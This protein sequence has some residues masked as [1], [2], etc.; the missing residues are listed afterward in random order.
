MKKTRGHQR[1]FTL[2]ELLVV[3]AII[4]VLIALLLPAVQQAREAARR[5]QCKNNMKQIGLAIHNYESSF[6]TFPSAAEGT[7]SSALYRQFFPV[8][9]FVQLLPYVDQAPLYGKWNFG[10]H[11]TNA[12]NAVLAKTP[13]PVYLCPSNGFSQPD[14]LGYGR[15][16]Y[17]PI[18][19]TDIDPVTGLRNGLVTG[20]SMGATRDG[21][22][23]L[24]GNRMAAVTDGLS[25]TIMVVEDNRI[26]T[27]PGAGSPTATGGIGSLPKTIG[28]APGIDVSQLCTGGVT[29]PDRWADPD[30]GS[31]ISGDPLGTLKVINNNSNPR[32]G[33]AGCPWTT[34]N[35][36]PNDEPFS[37]H[38]GGCHALLGDGSVRFLSE[39]MNTQ[40]VRRLSDKSDG[41]VIGEF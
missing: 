10:V 21:A 11:Y 35:C 27:T 30:I 2:I 7:N 31:G 32:G 24:Y 33:P 38:V 3:I 23:G 26:G 22:L 29:C 9:T 12:N 34:N 6:S 1:G 36:G 5:S 39:N 13:V 37:L 20:S 17:M 28:G 8:C 40:I 41:E 4:A 15:G 14:T 16:D 19:Y 25:M 18:A